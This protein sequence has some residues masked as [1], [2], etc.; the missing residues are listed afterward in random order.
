M[1]EGKPCPWED[2]GGMWWKIDADMYTA[3]AS[4]PLNKY[5]ALKLGEAYTLMSGY[6]IEN[7]GET[8]VELTPPAIFE[9][10]LVESGGLIGL[11]AASA[12]I[13]AF[14]CF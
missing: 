8:V 13:L 2:E 3:G 11:S 10:I 9:L 1:R 6:M 7:A 4:R 12:A 14:F 5:H